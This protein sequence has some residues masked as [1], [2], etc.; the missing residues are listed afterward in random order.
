MVINKFDFVCFFRRSKASKVAGAS[1][2]S[3]KNSDTYFQQRIFPITP[4]N[5][6]ESCRENSNMILAT[7]GRK[8]FAENI[9]A[10]I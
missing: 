8:N 1:L 3:K 4:E 9:Q 10:D 6:G 5:C 2:F 7:T